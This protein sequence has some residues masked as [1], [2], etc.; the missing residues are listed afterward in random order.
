MNL[1]KITDYLKARLL[2]RHTL[3][4]KLPAANCVTL[5]ALGLVHQL[6]ESG[7]NTFVLQIGACDGKEDDP[8]HKYLIDGNVQAVLV[9]PMPHAFRKLQQTYGHLDNVRL[10]QSAIGRH[11]GESTIYSV[12]MEGRW[13]TSSFAPMLSSFD[14]NHLLKHKILEN[15]IEATNVRTMTLGSLFKSY[16]IDRVNFMM[17]DTEGFDAE[18][19]GML[20]AEGLF[21]DKVCFEH[22]HLDQESIDNLFVKLKTHGYS[23]VN[24]RQNTLAIKVSLV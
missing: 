13:A 6:N 9:E 22:I 17:I 8:I 24:D 19:V 21:P 3:S 14:R 20:L 11:D 12:K 4:L 15:E 16:S 23:W 2:R 10:V 5:A 1:N 18:V 7:E